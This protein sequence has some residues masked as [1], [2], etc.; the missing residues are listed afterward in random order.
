MDRLMELAAYQVKRMKA[1][2]DKFYLLLPEPELVNISFWYI[3]KRLRNMKHGPEREKILGEVR[4]APILFLKS[5]YLVFHDENLNRVIPT[6]I[7]FRI[8]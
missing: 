3:P 1:M 6:K 8:H 5:I 4:S 2:P 7:L